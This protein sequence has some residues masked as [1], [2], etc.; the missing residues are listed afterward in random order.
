[1]CGRFTLRARPAAIVEHFALLPPDILDGLRLSP[2]FNIAPGQPVLSIRR[3]KDGARV[4]AMVRWGLVPHWAKD[5]SIGNRMINARAETL[6][7]KPAY[8]TA[9][10]RRRCLIP[11]DGFYEWHKKDAAKQPYFF[12]KK[13]DGLFAFAGLWERWEGADYSYLETFTI[14]TT[15]AGE[16]V[17]PYHDRMPVI[18]APEAYDTWLDPEADT[19]TLQTLLRPADD[20]LLEAYPVSTL[21]NRPIHD[22]P[23]CIEPV[24]RQGTLF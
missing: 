24:D 8:R 14:V 6:A 17:R 21:V 9:F 1:M 15:T 5:P 2:R 3:D 10:R 7:E 16:P 23:R 22:S 11:A 13:D 20:D 4:P 18:L 19:A 12:H